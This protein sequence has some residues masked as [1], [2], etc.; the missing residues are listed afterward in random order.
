[1]NLVSWCELQTAPVVLFLVCLKCR[2]QHPE[3]HLVLCFHPTGSS[4]CENSH[5]FK[6]RWWQSC[7]KF[8][9]LKK[10]QLKGELNNLSEG[11]SVSHNMLV[12]PIPPLMLHR[13]SVQNQCKAQK[14]AKS[15]VSLMKERLY[16]NW[17]KGIAV[18]FS[19]QKNNPSGAVLSISTTPITDWKGLQKSMT[20]CGITDSSSQTICC[21]EGKKSCISKTAP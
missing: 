4:S 6:S 21:G 5:P 7:S 9:R 18:I 11:V 13:Y 3:L 10:E 20:R 15:F 16:L 1:M 8:T 14:Q 2:L 19:Q 17:A 12:N